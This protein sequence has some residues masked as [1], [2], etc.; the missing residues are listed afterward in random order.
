MLADPKVNVRIKL[1]TLW[2]C[3]MALYI[4]ADYFLLMTPDTLKNMMAQK[5]EMGPVTPGILIGFAVI[6]IIPALMMPISI[7]LKPILSKWFNITFGAIYC[8][9]SLD[10]MIEE[11]SSQ[12]TW[13]YVLFQVVELIVL[14]FII[15]TAWNWPKEV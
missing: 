3:I 13:F 12:W 14:G 2:A 5:N 1:A 6:L 9:F 10:I 8:L 15:H 11:S 4:Y 7:L